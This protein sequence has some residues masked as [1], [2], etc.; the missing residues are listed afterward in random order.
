MTINRLA[1]HCQNDSLLSGLVDTANTI[2]DH[3][4]R[5]LMGTPGPAPKAGCRAAPVV[6]VAAVAVAFVLARVAGLGAGT[7]ARTLMPRCDMVALCR[8][9]GLRIVCVMR[10]KRVSKGCGLSKPPLPQIQLGL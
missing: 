6:A 3:G 10:R 2:S 1:S 9:S 7:C 4:L 5:I 8:A